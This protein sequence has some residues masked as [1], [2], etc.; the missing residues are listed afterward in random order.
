M[1]DLKELNKAL[2]EAHDSIDG[3]ID[4]ADAMDYVADAMVIAASQIENQLGK[5]YGS[6]KEAM[7]D[8]VKMVRK[9][10]TSKKSSLLNKFRRFERRGSERTAREY[11]RKL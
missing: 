10:V 3:A 11:K 2:N 8:I 4:E 5:E 7:D 6:A 9:L 1:S